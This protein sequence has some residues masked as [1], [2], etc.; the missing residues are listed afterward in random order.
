MTTG[1]IHKTYRFRLKTTGVHAEQF[2]RIAGVCRLVWNL[3]LEQR[4]LVYSSSRKFMDSYNQ[5]PEVTQLRKAY[6]FPSRV[7]RQK[8]R[9]PD[10]AYRN[11]FG[12]RAE[13]PERKKKGRSHDSFRVQGGQQ[14]D[15]SAEDRL[16]RILQKP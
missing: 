7:L 9:D 11:F 2:A 13:F 4:T 3:C 10:T 14:E 15:L 12:G 5:L 16:D 6:D 8:V 1:T